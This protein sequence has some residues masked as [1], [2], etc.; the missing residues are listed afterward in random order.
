MI[1]GDVLK[2][3]CTQ[4][5]NF[6]SINICLFSYFSNMFVKHTLYVLNPPWFFLYSGT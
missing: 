5:E 3:T 1:G 2:Y 6:F 4:A